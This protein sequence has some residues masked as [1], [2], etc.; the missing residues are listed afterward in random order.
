MG[1]FLALQVCGTIYQLHLSSEFSPALHPFRNIGILMQASVEHK[2]MNHGIFKPFDITSRGQSFEYRWL[3]RTKITDRIE[4]HQR[5]WPLGCIPNCLSVDVSV[6]LRKSPQTHVEM[7]LKTCPLSSDLLFPSQT[8]GW[9]VIRGPPCCYLVYL[10]GT[11]RLAVSIHKSPHQVLPSSPSPF[12]ATCPR[13]RLQL[14]KSV[15]TI[16]S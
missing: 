10:F 14:G 13:T 9:D 1:F 7:G 11:W 5:T 15:G 3:M 12:T 4:H 8:L 2:A 6:I 16:F